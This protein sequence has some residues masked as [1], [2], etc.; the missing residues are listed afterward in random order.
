MKKI[1]EEERITYK[2]KNETNE[3]RHKLHKILYISI[4]KRITPTGQNSGG[5]VSK[6]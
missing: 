4:H 3:R 5:T 6:V 1:K 2:M